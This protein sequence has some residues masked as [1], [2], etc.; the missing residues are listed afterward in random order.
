MD[1]NVMLLIHPAL[2]G[3]AT[4]AALWV[5][6]DTLN[7]KEASQTRIKYISILCAALIWLTYIIGGYWYVVHYAPEKA[8]IKA[9][10]WPFAH[11]IF[12]ETKEHVFLMLLLLST[13]LPIAASG[14]VA[15]NRAARKVL[16]WVSGLG[17]LDTVLKLVAELQDEKARSEVLAEVALVQAMHGPAEQALSTCK[18]IFADRNAHLPAVAQK[19][20]DRGDKDN[21]K[22]ML[23]P[24]AYYLDASYAM[25]GLLARLYP[26]KAIEVVKQIEE[27]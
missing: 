23:V 3:L 7:A 22:R 16:L 19:L 8:I 1:N 14:K 12:M 5:F 11:D 15:A 20:A 2:G 27:S 4:L 25:C 17:E 21:F 24:C 18:R 9:G 13:Y 26:Q 6:V 10:P